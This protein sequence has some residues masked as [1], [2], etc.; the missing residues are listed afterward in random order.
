MEAHFT[1]LLSLHRIKLRDFHLRAFVIHASTG[2]QLPPSSTYPSIQVETACGL[3]DL[4]QSLAGSSLSIAPLTLLAGTKWRAI[5][6]LATATDWMTLMGER[7][8]ETE[9]LLFIPIFSEFRNLE[10]NSRLR[11]P[12]VASFASH[13]V[14]S[15]EENCSP[16][17]VRAEWPPPPPSAVDTSS[18]ATVTVPSVLPSSSPSR[19][20]K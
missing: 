10:K 2:N 17:A 7:W 16:V 11:P 20:V 19:P 14:R 13:V 12:C 4:L 5:F 8:S 1:L 18:M 3:R 15:D 6:A 9:T